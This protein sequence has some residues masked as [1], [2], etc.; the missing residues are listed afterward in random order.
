MANKLELKE[1]SQQRKKM[2]GQ[3]TTLDKNDERSQGGE[4]TAHFINH[5]LRHGAWTHFFSKYSSQQILTCLSTYYF[6][7]YCF[8]TAVHS[9]SRS[10]HCSHFRLLQT[11]TSATVRL[12]LSSW[13]STLSKPS[14]SVFL[15]FRRVASWHF[16]TFWKLYLQSFFLN[17]LP[18]QLELLYF[19]K[20]HSI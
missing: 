3:W 20:S 9:L 7:T 12:F 17:H 11:N 13:V 6:V 18:D 1:M 2:Y 19:Y 5:F 16:I 15:F 4:Y 10:E 14:C 8:I